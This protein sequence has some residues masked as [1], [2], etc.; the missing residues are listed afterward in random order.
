[1]TTRAVHIVVVPSLEAETCLTAIIPF[2]A[3]RGKPAT[4]LSNIGTN[5]AGAA[6]EMKNC[7]N[8]WNQSNIEESLA[9]K[10][11]KW[12]FNL[13]GAPHFGG[14][15]ERSVRSCKTAMK[16]V[17]DGRSLT[18]H[19][20][21]TT[22]CSVEQTSNARS[23]ISVKDDLDDS[24]ALT[25][26]HFLVGRANLATPFPTGAQRYT[27]LRPVFGVSQAYSDMMWT[28][29]TSG[30]LPDWI[31]RNQWNK[32]DVR[33]L[34]VNELVSVVNENVKR[35]NYKMATV[36]QVQEGSDGRVRSATVV[37]KDVKLE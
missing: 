29:L 24:E 17:L 13:P 23:L 22:M 1:M 7:I 27:D 25:P 31:V 12:K 37:T 4:I 16:A 35:S 8:A 20:L 36:L 5:L 26:T 34:K 32:D 2:F 6:K 11:I 21:I 30:Y 10:E 28:R 15:W 14:I 3:R 33:Q 9:Q 19:V 18:D